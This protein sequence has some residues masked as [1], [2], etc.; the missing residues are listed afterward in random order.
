[1]SSLLAVLCLNDFTDPS[2]LIMIREGVI[3]MFYPA[4][5][6]MVTV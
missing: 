3:K 2:R 5:P 4:E 6:F 1:M